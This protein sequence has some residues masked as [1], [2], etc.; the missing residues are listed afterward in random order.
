MMMITTDTT[1]PPI[2]H[3]AD[4]EAIV[5]A[6]DNGEEHA[7]RLAYEQHAAAV[8]GV[9]LGVLRDPA[10]AEDVTQEVFLRLWDRPER[11]RPERG[12]LRTF[13]QMD[14]HG[15]SV[16]MIRSANAASRRDGVDHVERT[17][18]AAAGTEELAM[19]EIVSAEVRAALLSLP[20]E[21]RL[22]ITLA[23]FDGYSYRDVADL[24]SVPEGTVKSRIRA[25]MQRLRL[26]M[27][28]RDE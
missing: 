23:F 28:G 1:Y 22:P 6:I 9:A 21:Q 8:L 7:L 4:D 2:G 16:D 18:A 14:A 25:G 24:L 19:T 26:S 20:D 10:R 15:R 12:T 27:G 13:L 5:S 17:S 11:F 3:V